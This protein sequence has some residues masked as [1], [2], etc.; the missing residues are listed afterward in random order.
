MIDRK[1]LWIT[2]ALAAIMLAAAVWRIA[3]LPDWMEFPVGNGRTLHHSYFALF[4]FVP[5]LWMAFF[6]GVVEIRRWMARGAAEN[7]R[8]WKKWHS[9]VLISGGVL[10]TAMQFSIIARSLSTGDILNP[11]AMTRIFTVATGLLMIAA[12]NRL[13]KLPWLAS[14][15]TIL[16]LPSAKGAELLRFQGWLNV[17]VGVVFVLTGA[18]FASHLLLVMLSTVTAALIV[19]QIRRAQLKREQSSGL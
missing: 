6:L 10:V 11:F 12:G 17:C 13:P 2:S 16:D 7:I 8:P 19:V 9:L 1:T 5:P 3:L 15:L 18:F 14:R 4:L